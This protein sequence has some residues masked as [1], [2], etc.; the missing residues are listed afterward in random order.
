[1]S[2][3]FLKAQAGPQGS[4]ADEGLSGVMIGRVIRNCDQK[5]LGRVQVRL[6]ARGG[7][8]LWA[9]VALTDTGVYFIPQVGDQVLVAFHQG[10]DNEAYIMGRLW[11][12]NK[13]PPRQGDQDPVNQRVIRTPGEH[14]IAF[15]D[16]EQ[17]VVITTKAGQH[18]KLKK[19]T[20]EIGVDNK[21][22]AMIKLDGEGNITFTA[23]K[24]ITLDAPTITLKAT[25]KIQVGDASTPQISIG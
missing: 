13:L 23:K 25:S 11:N 12:D 15:D 8:E 9:K 4:G 7:K 2:G 6:A 21:S 10:D 3:E 22:S 14:E 19:D 24:G 5:L 1:M 16:K 20:V 18:V 17:S